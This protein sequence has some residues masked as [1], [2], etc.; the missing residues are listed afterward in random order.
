MQGVWLGVVAGRRKDQAVPLFRIWVSKHVPE[1]AE[2]GGQSRHR[3]AGMFRKGVLESEVTVGGR[4]SL[5]LQ[6]HGDACVPFTNFF[7][8][9]Y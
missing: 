4:P 9:Q 3:Q 7:F 6:I 5:V 1:G 2:G 8:W